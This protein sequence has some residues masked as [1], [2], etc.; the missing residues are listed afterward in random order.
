MNW[1]LQNGKSLAHFRVVSPLGAG[2]MGEVYL[3]EDTRLGRRVA[4]K[5]LTERFSEDED[6]LRRF[7]F[8]AR[9]V[10]A[11]NH[12]NIITVYDVGSDAAVRFI[13][14]EFVNDDTLRARISAGRLNPTQAIDIATQVA[15]ALA[16]A[17]DAGIVHR[18]LKP[19]NVMIRADGYIKV[20]DFGLAKLFEASASLATDPGEN[21]HTETTPGTIL[22]TYSY[23]SPEQGRGQA[24]DHRSDLFSLGVIL[25]EMLTGTRPF[26]GSSMIDVLLA[27][28]STEPPPV[29]KTVPVPPGVDRFVAKA[30]I[31]NPSERFQSAAEMMAELRTLGRQAEAALK[32]SVGPP[33][34]V[35][36]VPRR[37]VASKRHDSSVGSVAVLPLTNVN[38]EEDLEYLSDG[39]TDSLINNLSL[40]PRL[41]VL[42]RSTVFRYKTERI[43]PI[44]VGHT[45]GVEAVLTG[46]V[47]RRAD[48]LIVGA[49]LV[50]VSE[51]TQI[52]G[53][54]IT[55]PQSDVFSLQDDISREIADALRRRLAIEEEPKR[56]PAAAPKSSAYE[57]YLKGMYFLNR[58]TPAA[59][60]RAIEWLEQSA[61]ADPGFAPAHAGLADCRALLA[62]YSAAP[63]LIRDATESAHRAL[64]LDETL[65]EAHASLAFIKFRYEMDWAGAELE[66]QRAL[67]LNPNL[68]QTRHWHGM[69]LAARRRFDEAL[70]EIH[71]ARELDPLSLGVQCGIAR[72]LHFAGRYEEARAEFE[73]LLKLDP[74]FIR[75]RLDLTMTLLA[76]GRYREARE[77]LE[78]T[79]QSSME[80]FREMFGGMAAA[81]EGDLETARVAYEKLRGQYEQGQV[82]ADQL[83]ALAILLGKMDEAYRL[84]VEAVEKKSALLAYVNVEPLAALFLT[85]PG[86]TE[87]FREHGLLIE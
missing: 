65:A 47:S 23:M 67:R 50:N 36:E 10:A 35:A 66:F 62:T 51:G 42:A 4:L 6:R 54:Q 57:A 37:P 31:K 59:F 41:R 75:A 80:A 55:R 30:L 19:E 38:Q 21:L 49:E 61:A 56:M 12:P 64:A 15:G 71:R 45:L 53:A 63:D 48:R 76:M 8:E 9:T 85:V 18:D 3:A 20:L 27:I 46:R 17:H 70:A 24:V 44:A 40:V 52:W 39:L 11:L 73:R 83:A 78:K 60:R 13:A 16:A 82:S 84:I 86:V 22:G 1:L 58:R 74:S 29:S 87:L 32:L 33:A 69:F 79:D 26:A 5:V 77:G 25:Y 68:A 81:R 28:V 43:D 72:I 14:T 34:P 7:E 2:G